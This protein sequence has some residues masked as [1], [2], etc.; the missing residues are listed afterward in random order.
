MFHGSH[1]IG[2]DMVAHFEEGETWRKVFGPVF[3]YLNATNDVSKAH[4]LWT[5]A[6]RQVPSSFLFVNLAIRW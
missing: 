6:K 1:Y 4:N 2:D 3:I 5:D